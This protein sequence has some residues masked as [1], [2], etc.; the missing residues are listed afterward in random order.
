MIVKLHIEATLVR[1]VA[2]RLG[3]RPGSVTYTFR[4][5]ADA[6]TLLEDHWGQLPGVGPVLEHG[7]RVR[8][9]LGECRVAVAGLMS[10]LGEVTATITGDGRTGDV[11]LAVRCE[12]EA[13]WE[14]ADLLEALGSDVG[15]IV[16][17]A[18]DGPEEVE[19]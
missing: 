4:G 8:H 6:P 1:C 15:V 2:A 19:P 18:L 17:A 3:G 14:R 12:G 7:G 13:L 5:A 10:G 11:A 16:T 9:Q